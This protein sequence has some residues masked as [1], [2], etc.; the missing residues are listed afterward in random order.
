[1]KSPL[2]SPERLAFAEALAQ[3]GYAQAGA[4]GVTPLW[5]PQNGERAVFRQGRLHLRW[6]RAI[7]ASL[8]SEYRQRV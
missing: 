1:M 4:R 8:G 2:P 7:L 5:I 6:C 3:A